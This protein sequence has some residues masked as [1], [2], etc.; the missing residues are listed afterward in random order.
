MRR[1]L[2]S[3][4][5]ISHEATQNSWVTRTPYAAFHCHG[6]ASNG[7]PQRWNFSPVGSD[8]YVLYNY[9]SGRCLQ[10]FDPQDIVQDSCVTTDDQEWSIVSTPYDPSMFLLQSVYWPSQ[11][12]AA[13]NTS[14]NDHTALQVV[15]CDYSA[16]FGPSLV[17][18]LFALG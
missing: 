1:S 5:G 16:T 15:P 18:Q 8:I 2:I 3:W 10:D 17:E 6:Y 14:G 4:K 9:A 12:L 11:C 7:D 13:V